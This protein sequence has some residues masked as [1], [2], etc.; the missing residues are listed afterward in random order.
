MVLAGEQGLCF[1]LNRAEQ[2][3][4]PDINSVTNRLEALNKERDNV[5]IRNNTNRFIN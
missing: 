5:G 4:D 1:R 2:S 3:R